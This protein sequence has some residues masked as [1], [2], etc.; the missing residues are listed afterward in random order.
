MEAMVAV[1]VAK[2]A[3]DQEPKPPLPNVDREDGLMELCN[4]VRAGG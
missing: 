2:V 1:A 4:D 3:G